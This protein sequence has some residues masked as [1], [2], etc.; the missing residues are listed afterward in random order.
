MKPISLL[1]HFCWEF[2]WKVWKSSFSRQLRDSNKDARLRQGKL[3]SALTLGRR[4]IMC[5]L[6]MKQLLPWSIYPTEFSQNRPLCCETTA[7]TSHNVPGLLNEFALW[8]SLVL[9]EW[10]MDRQYYENTNIKEAAATYIR[11]NYSS[12]HSFCQ[13]NIFTGAEGI[14]EMRILHVAGFKPLKLV[15]HSMKDFIQ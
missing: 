11:A 6:L 1:S 3:F 15:W 9:C 12:D 14:D 2:V 4:G 7:Q 8:R 13:D 5:C 10:I